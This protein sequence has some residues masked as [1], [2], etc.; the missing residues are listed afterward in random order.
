VHISCSLPKTHQP[1]EHWR[2]SQE[3]Y[4]CG[5]STDKQQKVEENIG[6]KEGGRNG[7]PKSIALRGF[8][9]HTFHQILKLAEYNRIQLVWVPGHTGIGR[10]EMAHEIARQGPSHPLI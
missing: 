6:N 7:N 3:R 1:P 8:T 2:N 10:N 4:L 5:Y 9:H